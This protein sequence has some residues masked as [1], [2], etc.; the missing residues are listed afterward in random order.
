M[1]SCCS[2]LIFFG[3]LDGQ[4]TFKLSAAKLGIIVEVSCSTPASLDAKQLVQSAILL[5]PEWV[6]N[7]DQRGINCVWRL[8]RKLQRGVHN[9]L[10]NR[11]DVYFV[12]TDRL[13]GLPL[14]HGISAVYSSICDLPF[15]PMRTILFASYSK[16]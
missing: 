12:K 13:H 5:A 10:C 6:Y 14:Y 2:R 7:P 1:I 8:I 16:T 15:L 9:P 11:L 3:A 4:K